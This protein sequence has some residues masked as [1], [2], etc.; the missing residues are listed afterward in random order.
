MS[1]L[2]NTPEL[3]N[4]AAGADRFS[5]N[6]STTVFTLTRKVLS[7]ND[8][9]AVVENVVQDPFSAYTLAANTTSGTAD[10]TFTSAPP[11]GTN[12]IYISY[13]ATTLVTYDKVSNSQ[14]DT[15][16]VSAGT[17]GGSANIPV[18][19]VNSQGRVTSASNTALNLNSI[20]GDLTVSGNVTTSGTGFTK[21]AVGT[22]AQRPTSNT[23]GYIRYNT[24]LE[25]LELW[26]GSE[27]TLVKSAFAATGGTETTDGGYKIHTFTSSGSFVVSKGSKEVDYL[28]VAGGGGG[29]AYTGNAYKRG[30]TGSDSVFGS[31]TSLGGGGG[32]AS[33]EP[34]TSGG[35]G[36]GGSGYNAPGAGSGTSGQ[37]YAGGIGTWFGGPAYIGGGGGGA[38]AV[39]TA[40]APGQNGPGGVGVAVNIS[41][42]SVYY[43]GGG[44]AASWAPAGAAVGTGGN[45]G[46]GAGG[47]SGNPGT[48]GTTNSGGGGGA[49][50]SGG[51]AG[52]GGGGAGGLRSTVSAT[53]GGGALESKI[54]VSPGTYTVTVGAGGAGATSPGGSVTGGNGGSGIVIVRYTI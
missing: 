43:S 4:F 7:A 8:V 18:V 48:S 37:G 51:G 54:T 46:G 25:Q 17:Y 53:G 34:A 12:N 50:D 45:G 33:T 1:Y 40:A 24:T 28:V 47:P 49:A 32:G 35:S 27:W 21:V 19:V 30:G 22:T 41:G 6:G 38:G 26:T 14:L 42:S 20:T 23:T 39:G 15:T 3:Y 10:L 13:R 52:H 36:G 31:V 2:G 9:I 11:S 16:G 5:G 44:G 29:A